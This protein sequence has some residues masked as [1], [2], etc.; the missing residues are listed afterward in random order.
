VRPSYKTKVS[1]Q[2]ITNMSASIYTADKKFDFHKL[3]L[4]PPTVMS[5]GN[6]FIR[7]VM[8]GAPLYIQPPKCKTKGGVAK[9]GKRHYTDLLFTN[10][11][12]DFI[13]WMEDLET[14]TCNAIYENRTKWFE[15]EMDLTDVENYFASPLKIYKSGK[16][17]LART[18]ISTRLGKI[19]LKIYNEAEEEVEAD[20]VDENTEIVTI[21]EVQGIKCSARS[22]QIEM[23][24][25]QMMT[26]SPKELLFEKCLLGN[27]KG[28][29]SQ[30][31]NQTNV[32][33]QDTA[34]KE[35]EDEE[36][37]ENE[38][39]EAKEHEEETE[40]HE[41]E[42]EEHEE[43][44]EEKLLDQEAAGIS[45]TLDKEDLPTSEL[46]DFKS[47][48]E[49][50][51]LENFEFDLTL[52]KVAETDIVQIKERNEVYYEK[53]REARKKAK[54]ARNLALRAYLE[55]KQIKQ[56]Y[57]L[58]DESEDSADDTFWENHE[59]MDYKTI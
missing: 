9:S 20:T 33:V 22:F 52:D 10:E 43:E 31:I 21:L 30:D 14:H 44:T 56:T 27:K 26:V 48:E 4:T 25:K 11:N 38:E 46:L 53:Y 58:D 6:Y 34:V 59:N 49:P 45:Q 16:F 47:L 57:M 29:E 35:S 28:K 3:I 36:A 5:G 1:R 7:Y 55:A 41:E 2:N 19:S 42:T 54:I 18:N 8:D 17:Y 32:L 40:E 24:V 15:T 13:Q 12:A 23:E 51:I 39:E 50:P 37:K